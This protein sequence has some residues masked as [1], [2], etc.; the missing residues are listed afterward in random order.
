MRRLPTLWRREVKGAFLSPVAWSLIAIFLLVSGYFF[1][2]LLYLYGMESF[3]KMRLAEA[4]GPQELTVGHY[5]LRPLV[6]N[7]GVVLLML[8]PLV[9]M[10]LFSEEKR[11][12]SIEMLFTWPL[13]DLEVTLGKY[14][15]AVTV[16]AAMLLPTLLFPLFL[17]FYGPTPWGHVGAAWLGLFLMGGAFIALG[18]FVSSL[19]E[20]QVV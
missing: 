20:N 4:V 6:N 7:L 16:Y 11:S 5:A 17:S 2:S 18:L 19:T 13:T 14:L 9:T 10:R 15:A 12:G 8:L 3:E 1:Y